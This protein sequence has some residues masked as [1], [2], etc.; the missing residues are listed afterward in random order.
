MAAGSNQDLLGELAQR[1]IAQSHPLGRAEVE[2]LPGELPADRK[3][4]PVVPSAGRLIG[5]AV[6]RR[7]GKV[8]MVQAV[9]E[10]ANPLPK[11]LGD[12]EAE[13]GQEG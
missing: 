7:D 4:A 11:A 8:V 9:V 6:H 2:L 5:S 1:L 13:L 3:L 10:V 12:Y